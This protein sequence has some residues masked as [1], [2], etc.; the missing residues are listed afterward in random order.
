MHAK[1]FALFAV[2]AIVVALASGCAKGSDQSTTSSSTTTTTTTSAPAA[3]STTPASSG[4]STKGAAMLGDAAHG[5]TIFGPN[6]SSCHGATGTEGGV[7]PSLKGEKSKKTYEQTIAWIHNPAPP[8]PKLWP[9]PL[10]DKD[11][12]DVATYVQGL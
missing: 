2:G 10:N 5:K 8:M 9:S 11:V 4:S 6:C 12:A 1:P 7:G 3:A